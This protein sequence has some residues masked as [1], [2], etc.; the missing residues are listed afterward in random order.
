MLKSV[1][2]WLEAKQAWEQV[3]WIS[4]MLALVDNLAGF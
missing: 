4:K 3:L 1:W 2:I